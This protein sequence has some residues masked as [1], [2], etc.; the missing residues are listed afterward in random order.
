MVQRADNGPGP[1]GEKP[2]PAGDPTR[3]FRS[4]G[5]READEAV[6]E[7]MHRP[8]ATAKIRQ[9]TDVHEA[10]SETP[11]QGLVAQSPMPRA[12]MA[13]GYGLVTGIVATSLWRR[14]AKQSVRR[15]LGGGEGPLA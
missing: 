6:T 3:S 2:A 10:G 14:A 7:M 12:L 1:K 11:D 8:S 4:D 5:A 13:F 15:A 9:P